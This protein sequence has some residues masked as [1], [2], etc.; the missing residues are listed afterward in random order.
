[1]DQE[2]S[3]AD[4]PGGVLPIQWLHRAVDAGW[5]SAPKAPFE[6]GQFQPA[7][8]DLRLGPVA[9]RIRSSFLPGQDTV[10]QK[11]ASLKMYDI[12]LTPSAVLERGHAYLIPLM[13]ELALPPGV[14]AKADPK[15]STGRLDIFT[16]IITDLQPRFDDIRAGYHGKLYLEVF[17]RSFTIK[18]HAGLSLNQLRLFSGQPRLADKALHHLHSTDPLL[19][20]DAD[21]PLA[22]ESIYTD[23]GLFLGVNI[24]GNRE[25]IVGY[26]AKKNSDIIDLAR[27]GVYDP[28]AFWEPL[29][30]LAHRPFILE[31]EEFYILASKEK[32]CI[33]PD[34]AA[35]LMAYDTG[36]GE[37]RTHYAGFFDPGFGYGRNAHKGTKAVLEVRPHDVPFLVEDGQLFCK[38]CLDRTVERPTQLYGTDLNSH[39]QSQALT[40]SK[41]FLP[42]QA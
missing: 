35:E 22:P 28:S 6:P 7:S 19:Y 37:L 26:K 23:G 21:Q 4:L 10:A 18:V 25:A 3:L 29:Y 14:H 2:A 12:A 39:Y 13:E 5:L 40:L 17:S 42:W 11:L 15:S 9:Y 41:L 36:S 38:L 27:E 30:H 8:L 16:R 34:Y 31:P 1:M 20:D 24:P 33:P 32:V